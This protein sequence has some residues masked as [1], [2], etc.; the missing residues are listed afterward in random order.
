MKQFLY[1]DVDR[2]NSII[3]QE[4]KGLIEGI[5][6]EEGK[7]NETS[8]SKKMNI[9]ATGEAGASIWKLA[10]AEASLSADFEIEGVKSQQTA[11]K[12]IIAKTLHDA[13]YDIAYTAISPIIVDMGKDNADPG[14][15]VELKRVFQV[16]DLEYLEGLFSEK[17]IIDFIK[18]SEK[19]KIEK[20][21]DEYVQDNLN[22]NQRRQNT[23]DI[24]KIKKEQ[25]SEMEKGYDEIHKIIAA[26]GNIVPY[27]HMLVS[28]DGYLIPLEDKYFRVNPSCLGFMYGG[29]IKCVGMITN[30]M[31][32]DT[33]PNDGSDIF[34][35][36][37]FSVNE[38]LR[39]ILPTSENN[40]YVVSPIAIYYEN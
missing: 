40:L 13:A 28:Y 30:I 2:I 25:I 8:K 32:K 7:E 29:E 10:K 20:A 22:R 5:T 23:T 9:G 27:K 33:N 15:Y 3:A 34:A 31:G 14:D 38:A 6:T 16:V 24:K 39:S 12:E 35:T 26:L 36:I 11:T 18:Q 1:L 37:Q 19:E 21:T 17:G 4:G